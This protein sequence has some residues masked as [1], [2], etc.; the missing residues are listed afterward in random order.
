MTLSNGT[1]IEGKRL[2]ADFV[3]K[4]FWSYRAYMADEREL[5]PKTV[6]D[7]LTIIKQLFKYAATN[8]LIS[9]NPVA[10]AKVPEAPTTVQPC[11]SPRQVG[12]LLAAADAFMKV[13]IA[14]LVFTGMRVGELRDLLWN[15]VHLD[16][17]RCGF[18]VVQRGGSSGTTKNRKIRRI[19][20]HPELRTILVEQSRAFDRVV[21]A[22]PC[23]KYPKGGMPI[24]DRTILKN[25][26]RLCRQCKFPSPDSFKTH[27]LRHAFCSMC[28]RQNVSYRYALEWMGHAN[29]DILSIYYTMFDETAELAIN[30]IAY[31][32]PKA[33][34]SERTA[35]KP[36][37]GEN[38]PRSDQ[39][40]KEIR[41]SADRYRAEK[42]AG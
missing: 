20:I 15:D 16:E 2:A 35:K 10:G 41:V 32:K 33:E 25:L 29:S 6:E 14:I 17:G 39:H 27:S 38:R 5:A 28:A 30:T 12:A 21:T 8:N 40:G 19:P 34:R 13:V 11:F 31:P 36:N 1:K 24:N 9:Q 7:R 23:G 37:P 26:K 22:P 42:A 18:I 3:E 4:D